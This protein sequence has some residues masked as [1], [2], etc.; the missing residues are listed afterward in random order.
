[1]GVLI[2]LGG[3]KWRYGL[4]DNAEAIPIHILTYSIKNQLKK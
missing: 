2:I 3:V 4:T 1:M